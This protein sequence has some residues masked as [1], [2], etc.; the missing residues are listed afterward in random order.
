MILHGSVHPYVWAML[1]SH[2]IHLTARVMAIK[3]PLCYVNVPCIRS[4]FPTRLI[5]IY[6]SGFATACSPCIS[7]VLDKS[8]GPHDQ[9][10]LLCGILRGFFTVKHLASPL[11]CSTTPLRDAHG[12][13]TCCKIS[14]RLFVRSRVSVC[15]PYV[16]YTGLVS[17]LSIWWCY[18]YIRPK[19]KT[20]KHT[21]QDMRRILVIYNVTL[22]NGWWLI[23]PIRWNTNILHIPSR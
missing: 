17:A 10:R 8:I 20:V 4:T 13:R 3:I 6:V 11:R 18:I 9:T 1:T 19:K 21:K 12:T 7:C 5:C 2:L 22:N 14:T 23:F 16:S 15:A